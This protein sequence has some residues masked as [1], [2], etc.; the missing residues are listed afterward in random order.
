VSTDAVTCFIG[1]SK[2]GLG[3]ANALVAHLEGSGVTCEIWTD[4]FDLGKTTVEGLEDALARNSFAV[5][6]ATADDLTSSRG[7]AKMS[8]RDN[9]ILEFGLFVGRLRRDRAFLLVEETD[10]PIKLPTDLLGVTLG[11]FPQRKTARAKK[12]SLA[13]SA[14]KVAAQIE[15][16]GPL[17]TPSDPAV[18]NDV[19]MSA[20][21]LI[22]EL[23]VIRTVTM[24]AARRG[25]WT[26]AVLAAALEPFLARADDAYAAWLR[27]DVAKLLKIVDAVNLGEN[28]WPQH[29][30]KQGEGMAGKVWENARPLAVDRRR[31]HPWFVARPGCA[32]ETYLCA[33]LA[34]PSAREGLL[35]IGSDEGFDVRSGDLAVLAVY[36]GLLGFAM[37]R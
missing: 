28:E 6:I 37:P 10:K 13:E 11:F 18:A 1:S 29:A 7:R 35:V 26:K 25:A 20:S 21:E 34:G 4:A 12:A 27:P 23:R 3:Y 2:E 19:L 17:E 33:P 31:P 5:L 36:A 14:E 15:K 8:P 32:N 16:L 22:D 9:V 24:S 30:W